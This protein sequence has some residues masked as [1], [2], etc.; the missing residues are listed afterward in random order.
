MTEQPFCSYSLS[1]SLHQKTT[2]MGLD[3]IANVN[4]FI[5]EGRTPHNMLLPLC[6]ARSLSFSL[7]WFG[8]IIRRNSIDYSLTKKYRRSIFFCSC[9]C[10]CDKMLKHK[11]LNNNVVLIFSTD[12]LNLHVV[13]N[14]CHIFDDQWYENI[15]YF[16]W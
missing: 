14:A 15:Q 1:F 4:W 8:W 11:S 6:Y 10:S 5:I 16:V 2:K 12:S 13:W 3:S 9:C 7:P